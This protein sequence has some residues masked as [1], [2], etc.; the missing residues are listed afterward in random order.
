[1]LET[2]SADY[3]AAVTC[4]GSFQCHSVL[5]KRWASTPPTLH[6]RES[7][8]W[9]IQAHPDTSDGRLLH[10]LIV[11]IRD[12]IQ[13][14]PLS[15]TIICTANFAVTISEPLVWPIFGA[16]QEHLKL[17]ILTIIHLRVATLEESQQF[18]MFL[19][20]K[21]YKALSPFLNLKILRRS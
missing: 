14:A 12:E 7:T 3:G 5:S 8:V 11:L 10:V 19:T 2:S 17:L 15:S 21:F 1:M 18:Q 9:T 4:R 13:W 6:C 16:I 20:W